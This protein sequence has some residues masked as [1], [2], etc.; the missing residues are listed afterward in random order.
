MF[1]TYPICLK[2]LAPL[3]SIY[4]SFFSIG[5]VD[6]TQGTLG[7]SSAQIPTVTDNLLK[8]GTISTEVIGVYYAPTT[9]RSFHFAKICVFFG[10][11]GWLI[12]RLYDFSE[13]NTNGEL[14]FGGT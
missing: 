1:H 6:L 10:I 12:C 7:G 9:T 8:Q 4:I 5:P 11:F 3:T 14:T 2:L 13:G